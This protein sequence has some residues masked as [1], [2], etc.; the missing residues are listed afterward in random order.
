[1]TA[2]EGGPD[3]AHAGDGPGAPWAVESPATTVFDFDYTGGRDQLLRLYD[4]GT[5]RQWIG[6]ERLDWT[7]EVDPE[8]P[9]GMPDESHPHYGTPWWNKMSH[10]ERVELRRHAAAWRFSQFM[11]GEQGALVCTA[12]I[13]QTVPDIDAKFYAA[14]Q[15]IDEARHVEVYSRY[16]HEKVG[17]VYP[18]NPFLKTLLDNVISDSRWDMTYL[19]MQVLVEGLALAAFGL[20]RNQATEPLAKALNA[21][22]M[23]DEARHVMF[24]RLA[25]RDYYPQLTQAERDD[26]EAFCIEACYLMRDRFLG[27][28]IWER[29]ELPAEIGTYVESSE[30]LRVFRSFLF[31][32]IVPILRDIGLWGPKLRSAFEEMG[33]IGFADTDIDAEMAD[34]EKAAQDYDEARDARMAHVKAVAEQA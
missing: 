31:M 13:V 9:L 10:A 5:R 28:E 15:V 26:R 11:H 27:E 23:Q 12:K 6:S 14:T 21:Y 25:L 24:G 2:P 29:L 1:M 18:L 17:L 7:L 32:R 4:K 33:V 3:V 16:L 20:I 19:G 30:T 34:D 8:N 22:V